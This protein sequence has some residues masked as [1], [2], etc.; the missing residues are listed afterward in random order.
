[1]FNH[2][3]NGDFWRVGLLVFFSLKLDVTPTFTTAAGE[4]RIGLHYTASAT[5]PDA[6]QTAVVSGTGVTWPGGRT[7]PVG[8]VRAGDETLEV[9]FAGSGAA[10][11]NLAAADITSGVALQLSVTGCYAID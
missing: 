6:Y 8:L 9:A 3:C 10:V 4:A 1:M 7:S 2:H 5:L 11:Q